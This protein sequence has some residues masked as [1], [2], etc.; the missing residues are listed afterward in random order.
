[1][2]FVKITYF[3]LAKADQ[4]KNMNCG[5][6]MIASQAKSITIKHSRLYSIN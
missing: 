4:N 6:N 1:M 5:N 3:F 2:H